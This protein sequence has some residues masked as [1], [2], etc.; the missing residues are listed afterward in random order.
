MEVTRRTTVWPI[1]SVARLFE[2]VELPVGSIVCSIMHSDGP[3]ESR[4]SAEKK[5]LASLKTEERGG[6]EQ[7][8]S[9]RSVR[10]VG[11]RRA[12]TDN[13]I[14]NSTRGGFLFVPARV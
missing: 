5:E 3:L 10:S 2:L 7:T 6:S 1:S 4:R 13:V 9:Q 11:S 12:H 14:E 8:K